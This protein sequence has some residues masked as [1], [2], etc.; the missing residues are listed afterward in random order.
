MEV[1]SPLNRPLAGWPGAAGNGM[2]HMR[3]IECGRPWRARCLPRDLL[4]P[5]EDSHVQSDAPAGACIMRRTLQIG[6]VTK[7]ARLAAKGPRLPVGAAPARPD[8]PCE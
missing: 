3:G 2:R 5:S 7:R 1:P 8:S 4:R 6:Y